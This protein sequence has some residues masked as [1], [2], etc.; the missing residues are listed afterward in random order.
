[1][2]DKYIDHVDYNNDVYKI[3][4]SITGELTAAE[5]ST[6]TNTAGKFVSAKVIKDAILANEVTTDVNVSN[7]VLHITTGV[8]GG[9]GVQY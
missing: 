5:V 7:Q 1:M 2:P 4:D 3:K 9:D 8:S 6:G